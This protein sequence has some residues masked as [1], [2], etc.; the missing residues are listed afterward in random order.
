MKILLLSVV[1]LAATLLIVGCQTPA[2]SPD[3][4][5]LT[6]TPWML[7]ELNGKALTATDGLT[8]PTLTLDAAAKRASGV[9]GINRYSGGYELV[10]AKLKFG[11]FMGTRMAGPPAAMAVESEYL[12]TMS[13]VTEW[14]IQ[15]R[16][17]QLLG[18]GKVLLRFAPAP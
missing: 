13:A 17:L 2:P 9:S 1:M 5:P 4:L 6:G 8:T 16:E 7:T 18:D 3:L 11:M 10:E 14:K 15:G 12:Q